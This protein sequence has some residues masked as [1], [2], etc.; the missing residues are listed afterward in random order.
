MEV[1]INYFIHPRLKNMMSI[2]QIFFDEYNSHGDYEKAIRA[3]KKSEPDF[4]ISYHKSDGWRG[5]YEAKARKG[6]GWRKVEEVDGI[7]LPGWMTGEWEDA[8]ENTKGS[9]LDKLLKKL[10]ASEIKVIFLPTSN[11]FSTAYDVFVR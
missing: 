6:T 8:P 4:I 3:V 9:E 2:N 1:I 5:W 7:K 11:V 10:K